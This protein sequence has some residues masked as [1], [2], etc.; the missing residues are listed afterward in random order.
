VVQ[1]IF[2]DGEAKLLE[3]SRGIGEAPL[4]RHAQR[5]MNIGALVEEVCYVEERDLDRHA[6][7]LH[8]FG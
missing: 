8:R 2:R 7:R 6:I 5:P 4:I 3:I 1:S